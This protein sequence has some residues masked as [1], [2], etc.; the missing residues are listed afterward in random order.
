MKLTHITLGFGLVLLSGAPGIAQQAPASPALYASSADVAAL[1]AKAKN[2]RKTEPRIGETILRLDPYSV[3]LEYRPAVA[4]ASL[5]LHQA[6]LFYVIDGAATVV[7][8]GKLVGAHQQNAENLDGTAVEGGAT[9]QI[10]KGDFVFVPENTPH[11]FS[12]ISQTLVVMSLHVPRPVDAPQLLGTPPGAV[13]SKVYAST[14]DVAAL[15]AKARSIRKEGQANVP[16]SLLPLPPYSVNVEYRASVG[17]ATVHVH[18]AEL[19]YVIDG[20]ATLV[21]GGK[22]VNQAKAPADAENLAGDAIDGGKT[23]QIGKG[24]FIFVPENTPHWFSTINQTLVV[25]SV[26]VPRPV[27]AAH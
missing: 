9:Q 5:H 6:E 2:E 21:T 17:N 25:M 14:A 7:T 20:A 3:G 16:Q 23:Q 13:G 12:A 24:D 15:V 27:P 26:H 22:L 19:F 18:E 4:P 1:I 10:T 8:G 11:W